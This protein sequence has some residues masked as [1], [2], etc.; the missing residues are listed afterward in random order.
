MAT[1]IKVPTQRLFGSGRQR[2]PRILL[3]VLVG[4]V[5]LAALTYGI[6]VWV[7]AEQA[8]QAQV[9]QAAIEATYKKEF[10]QAVDVNRVAGD[11]QV[12]AA[13]GDIAGATNDMLAAINNPS[14]PKNS[15]V[16][17]YQLLAF[18]LSNA[19]KHD[20][21]LEYA[22][23]SEEL[24]SDRRSAKVIADVALAKKD[25]QLAAK[26]Y[27]TAIDRFSA[28]DKTQMPELYAEYEALLQRARK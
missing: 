27:Q 23:K 10:Q 9:R 22:N 3:A 25:S 11:A 17:L 12:K 24:I 1:I 6:Y 14:T 7:R 4:L 5:V 13:K 26:W 20:Q 16:M 19:G 28:Q 2:R 21:A 15:R 18:M 8:R